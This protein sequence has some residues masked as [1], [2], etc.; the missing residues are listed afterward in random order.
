MS[1]R[2]EDRFTHT[3]MDLLRLR[4]RL[5]PGQR[6]QAMF[7]AHAFLVGVTRGR[8]RPRYPQLSDRQLNLKVIEEIERAKRLPSRSHAVSRYSSEA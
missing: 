3:D 2:I 1:R 4:M 8:L 5:T 7:D 6:L